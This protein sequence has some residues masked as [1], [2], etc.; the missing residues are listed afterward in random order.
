MRLPPTL[1]GLLSLIN[2]FSHF[3]GKKEKNWRRHDAAR[4][5]VL[6]SL[7]TVV[8]EKNFSGGLIMS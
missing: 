4:R 1:K 8:R 5:A 3:T 2:K 7:P 6:S